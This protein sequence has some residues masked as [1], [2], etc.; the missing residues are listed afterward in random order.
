[1]VHTRGTGF[2]KWVAVQLYLQLSAV[3]KLIPH[4]CY[5]STALI[6]DERGEAFEMGRV[7][8]LAIISEVKSM[9]NTV[10]Y[11]SSA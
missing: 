11:R 9:L 1:M 10:W 7:I 3:V 6:G 4:C 2:V 5:S 8:C